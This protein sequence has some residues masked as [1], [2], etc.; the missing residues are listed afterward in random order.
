M[1]SV[2]RKRSSS[3]VYGKNNA[4]QISMTLTIIIS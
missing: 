2:E 3:S 4:N 1:D